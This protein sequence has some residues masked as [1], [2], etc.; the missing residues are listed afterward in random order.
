[1]S[2]TPWWLPD[3]PHSW[4][5]PRAS[6]V[7]RSPD[8]AYPADPG[9][10]RTARGPR[11]GDRLGGGRAIHAAAPAV[12]TAPVFEG[13]LLTKLRAVI[14]DDGPTHL[15][16]SRACG[17]R[18]VILRRLAAC[19]PRAA[20]QRM[21]SSSASWTSVTTTT[22]GRDRPTAAVPAEGLLR[23]RD[24]PALGCLRHD[25]RPGSIHHALVQRALPPFT[26]S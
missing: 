17:L 2:T 21:R 11:G 9:A 8:T 12:T 4:R 24:F 18:W 5:G 23:G 19:V 14:V 13:D 26:I 22:A 25:G 15:Q 10:A 20:K 6:P 16:R 1:M 7:P 3:G